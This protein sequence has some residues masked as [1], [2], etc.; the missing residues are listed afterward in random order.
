MRRTS[1]ELDPNEAIYHNDLRQAWLT[2]F[3]HGVPLPHPR[4]EDE[5]WIRDK[6]LA[7]ALK[8]WQR[9]IERAR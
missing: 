1:L 8:S 9:S 3:L 4:F 5:K 2:S 6:G 7:V